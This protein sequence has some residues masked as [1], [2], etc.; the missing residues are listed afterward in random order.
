MA[1]TKKTT[2]KTKQVSLEYIA[3]KAAAWAISEFG[4]RDAVYYLNETQEVTEGFLQEEYPELTYDQTYGPRGVI[5]L[6]VK[7]IED[8]ARAKKAGGKK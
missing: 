6:A 7:I 5:A 8:K 4:R 3:K 1:P 2:G